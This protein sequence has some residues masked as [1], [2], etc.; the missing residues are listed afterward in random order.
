MKTAKLDGNVCRLLSDYCA[1]NERII[2]AYLFGSQAR[3]TA[4]PIS[5]YDV[6]LLVDGVVTPAE[7]Y[8]WT[9]GLGQLLRGQPVDLVILN[10]VPVELRYN[11]IAEGSRVY[12]RDVAARVESEAN[13]LRLY[14]DMLP[15]LRQQKEAILRRGDRAGRIQ[16]YRE[17]LGQTL[18]VLTQIGATS[19]PEAEANRKPHPCHDM[20]D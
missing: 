9:H 20:Q 4:G 1:Q 7:R 17:A 6:A 5:D 15:M 13:T 11:V 14:G 12:E 2:L 18:R 8:R 16:R 19:H 10:T 3:G